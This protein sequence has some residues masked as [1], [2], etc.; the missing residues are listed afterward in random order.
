MVCCSFFCGSCGCFYRNSLLMYIVSLILKYIG[1]SNDV[2]IVVEQVTATETN[3]LLSKTVI[4]FAYGACE[5]D[6]ESGKCSS[7]SSN[8]LYDGKICIIC[9]D[10]ERNCFFVP[11]GHCATCYICA[12]RIIDEEIKT[13]PVCRRFIRKVRKMF[14]SVN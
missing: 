5:D 1:I 7:S 4:P 8:D 3:R 13:C 6:P 12:Q 9:Y 11:C 2:P 10:E 14:A